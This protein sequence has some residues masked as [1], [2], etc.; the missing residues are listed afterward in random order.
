[1]MFALLASNAFVP[2]YPKLIGEI[3][4]FDYAG[5]GLEKPGVDLPFREGDE[6][7]MDNEVDLARILIRTREAIKQAVVHPAP[8]I[9]P[10]CRDK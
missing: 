7:R 9:S 8:D 6:F 4:F 1:M 3:E 5:I 10:T 2:E